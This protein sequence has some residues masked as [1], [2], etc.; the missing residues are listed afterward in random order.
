MGRH[1]KR[2]LEENPRIL[3]LWDCL[4]LFGASGKTDLGLPGGY[5]VSSGIIFLNFLSRQGTVPYLQ[6]EG[7]I[8]L[9]K[10]YNLSADYLIGLSNTPKPYK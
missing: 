2:I 5:G 1:K 7:L 8:K 3:W 10:F 9:C 6:I 4:F